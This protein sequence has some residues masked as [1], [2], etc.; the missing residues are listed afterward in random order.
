[1]A[2]WLLD[3]TETKVQNNIMAMA[4][5][6]DSSLL[7]ICNDPVLPFCTQQDVQTAAV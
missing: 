1:M 3:Q 2:Q 4:C 7:Q 5:A 6:Q